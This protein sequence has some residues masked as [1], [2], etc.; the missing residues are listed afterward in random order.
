MPNNVEYKV[1]VLELLIVYFVYVPRSN[2]DV[3]GDF[4]VFLQVKLILSTKVTERVQSVEIP[5]CY[6][7]WV[8]EVVKADASFVPTTHSGRKRHFRWGVIFFFHFFGFIGSRNRG[9]S[10]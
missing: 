6:K 2:A 9:K 1:Y 7:S 8:S 5:A 10:R 4:E 3:V